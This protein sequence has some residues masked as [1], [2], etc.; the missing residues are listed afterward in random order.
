MFGLGTPELIVIGVIIFLIFGAKRLPDIG[1]GVGG[2]IREFRQVKK[3]LSV[4]EKE[5]KNPSLSLEEK[6]KDKT[7]DQVP[8]AK[9]AMDVKKKVEKVQ[10]IL[11]S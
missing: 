3:D 10:E 1:K 4:D 5:D 2:A 11:K 6:I 8:G 7:L 9:K